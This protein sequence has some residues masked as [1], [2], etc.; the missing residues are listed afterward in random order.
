MYIPPLEKCSH[1]VYSTITPCGSAIPGLFANQ[2]LTSLGLSWQ[3]KGAHNCTEE[4]WGLRHP[5]AIA[6]RS[7][8]HEGDAQTPR[9]CVRVRA[10]LSGARSLHASAIF[11]SVYTQIPYWNLGAVRRSPTCSCPGSWFS[12]R[13]C[14]N[15][16]KSESRGANG[17][18]ERLACFVPT[19]PCLHG[20]CQLA[21]CQLPRV[22]T[23][24]LSSPVIGEMTREL[25]LA[26]AI[27]P[28]VTT[29]SLWFL[30]NR[31]GAIA[32]PNPVPAEKG[33]CVPT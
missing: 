33:R 5:A 1:D 21:C 8:P 2:I 26:P 20:W 12:H 10:W 17:A 23:E 24:Y 27:R 25:F 16:A 9:P 3:R 14:I 13:A 19:P 22:C 28:S 15:S 4:H 30:S 18:E 7:E 6:K 29:C 32:N 31:C 11:C